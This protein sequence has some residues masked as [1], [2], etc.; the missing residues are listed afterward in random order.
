MTAAGPADRQQGLLAR[1]TLARQRADAQRRRT[2]DLRGR[3]TVVEQQAELNRFL[4]QVAEG[5]LARAHADLATTRAQVVQLRLD[6]AEVQRQR[7][8]IRGDFTAM[9]RR[10]LAAEQ[11]L[12]E[13]PRDASLA[14]PTAS[15]DHTSPP[16]P[17]A[18]A[19]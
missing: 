2:A 5:L 10:A 14:A 12:A 8:A 19:R 11:A 15:E 16:A 13:Q 7:N 6:H 18:S 1:L 9:E 3:L 4:H 17:G